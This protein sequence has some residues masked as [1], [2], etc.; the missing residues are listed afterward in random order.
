MK[1]KII[2]LLFLLLFITSCKNF[3]NGSDLINKLD[4]TIN[5]A[6]A[7][8][9]PIEFLL[10]D[11]SAGSIYPIGIQKYKKNQTFQIQLSLYDG[12]IL[13]GFNVYAKEGSSKKIIENAIS[14]STPEEIKQTGQILYKIDCKVLD[15]SNELLIVPILENNN[16]KNPPKIINNENYPLIINRTENQPITDIQNRTDSVYLSF[17]I[18]EI[19]NTPINDALIHFYSDSEHKNLFGTINVNLNVQSYINN[20]FNCNTFF[21]LD[22]VDFIAEDIE[23]YMGVEISDGYNNSISYLDK[24]LKKH[25]TSKSK[26]VIYNSNPGDPLTQ[27]AP[28]EIN[29]TDC[30]N[31][32][33]TDSITLKILDLDDFYIDSD[34]K[35]IIKWGYTQ[36]EIDLENITYKTIDTYE[37]DSEFPLNNIIIGDKNKNTYIKVITEPETY[38]N[39]NK[40]NVFVIPATPKVNYA[41]ISFDNSDYVNFGLEEITPYND[42]KFSY[43]AY[44]G[45]DSKDKINRIP[46]WFLN[47]TYDCTTTDVFI[48]SQC[49]STYNTSYNLYGPLSEEIKASIS[50][51]TIPA[52]PNPNQNQITIEPQ[53]INSDLYKISIKYSEIDLSNYNDFKS[54]PSW[55]FSTENNSLIFYITSDQIFKNITN[56]YSYIPNDLKFDLYAIKDKISYQSQITIKFDENLA[57]TKINYPKKTPDKNYFGYLI[58]DDIIRFYGKKNNTSDYEIKITY[59]G[60][61]IG[62]NKDLLLKQNKK[63]NPI[64]P[65]A[66]LPKGQ[67]EISFYIKDAYGNDINNK[68]NYTHESKD[69]PPEYNFSIIDNNEDK[70]SIIFTQKYSSSNSVNIIPIFFSN[71][72]KK[73]E[74]PNN[75]DF[76][77]WTGNYTSYPFYL[78]NNNGIIKSYFMN[79]NPIITHYPFNQKPTEKDYLMLKNSIHVYSDKPIFIHTLL[80]NYDWGEDPQEWEKHCLHYVYKTTG[81]NTEKNNVNYDKP[82][83]NSAISTEYNPVYSSDDHS[84]EPLKYSFP[85]MQSE[86]NELYKNYEYAAIVLYYADNT[87]E[88]IR[89]K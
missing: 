42:T 1:N 8:E 79:Y 34:N 45:E 85:W 21:T 12:V 58:V 76:S 63:E 89:L 35:P 3:S 70:P 9:F 72:D 18:Q 14:F 38:F 57:A 82:F 7:Q 4:E 2:Y 39:E 53:G 13:K 28:I 50:D 16:D 47:S 43:I 32:N 10:L 49:Y 75:L 86:G 51:P 56:S 67:Y 80:S 61:N 74:I 64:I 81:S 22:K 27:L 33:P 84:N 29:K 46:L 73:W 19:E 5:L 68:F 44:K 36:N 37:Q 69:I 87:S 20:F 83:F 60:I 30:E 52:L 65:I 62:Y 59:K 17:I 48:L 77:S 15:D 41:S 40:E 23:F 88:L 24:K 6:N 54:Y 55:N 25:F 31:Y 11:S 66:Q 26:L 78:N 71:K